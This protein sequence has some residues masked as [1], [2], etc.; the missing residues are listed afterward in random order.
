[1]LRTIKHPEIEITRNI[2]FNLQSMMMMITL[3][4]E[5]KST[6]I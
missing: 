5:T 4:A 3:A 1:M 2:S 6:V